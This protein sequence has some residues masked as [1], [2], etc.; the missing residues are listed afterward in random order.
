MNTAAINN[1][2]QPYKRSFPH[3]DQRRTLIGCVLV[4]LTV[5]AIMFIY[6]YPI[7]AYYAEKNEQRIEQHKL[8]ILKE[9]NARMRQERA[10]LSKDSEIEK[11]AREEYHLVK[12]GEDAYLVTGK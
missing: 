5:I 4:L 3:V 1:R 10:N 11:I 2:A 9:A 6:V 7:R 12:P 8:D